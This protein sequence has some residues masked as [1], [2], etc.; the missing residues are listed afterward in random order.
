MFNNFQNDQN[1][2]HKFLIG[3]II[4]VAVIIVVVVSSIIAIN[5][6]TSNNNGDDEF[7]ATRVVLYEDVVNEF[8]DCYSSESFQL[9]DEAVEEYF[10]QVYPKGETLALDKKEL[11]ESGDYRWTLISTNGQKHTMTIIDEGYS[12]TVE[13][14]GSFKKTYENEPHLD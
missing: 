2:H 10:S 7:L 1:N 3:G 14:D 12:V 6:N 11:L 4:L 5:L 13:I 9:I 8:Y